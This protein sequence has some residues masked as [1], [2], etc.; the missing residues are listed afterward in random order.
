MAPDCDTTPPTTIPPTTVAMST[1]TRR[2]TSTGPS[3]EPEPQRGNAL[4]SGEIGGL[5]LGLIIAILLLIFI[6]LLVVVLLR[7]CSCNN[8]FG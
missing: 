3:L 1:S 5:I 8:A 2:A 4:S 7:S 6:V